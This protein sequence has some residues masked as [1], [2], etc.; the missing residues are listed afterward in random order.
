M[1]DNISQASLGIQEVNQ[2]M[3]Q[4]SMVA[5]DIAADISAVSS[6]AVGMS[7]SSA[8]VRTNAEELAQLA[9]RLNAVVGRFR[10]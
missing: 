7:R 9:E 2:N 4:S 5:T 1:A 8:Q 3:A 10:Y 6:E